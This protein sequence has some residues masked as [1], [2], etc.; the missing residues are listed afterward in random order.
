[1]KNNAVIQNKDVAEKVYEVKPGDVISLENY[2]LDNLTF[3]SAG[4]HLVIKAQGKGDVTLLNFDLAANEGE[5]VVFELPDGTRVNAKDFVQLLNVPVNDIEPAAGPQSGT[6]STV[7]ED[8][9]F[10]EP[11]IISD[12]YSADNPISLV[13]D[14]IPF[15]NS[16]FR[17]DDETLEEDGVITNAN[18]PPAPNTSPD[19]VNDS[20]NVDED[21]ALNLT[22]AQ[23]LANDTDI[24]GDALSV[25]SVDSTTT[26]GGTVS[27]NPT[28]GAIVYTPA[29]NY[30]GADSFTYTISDGNGGVDTAT[31]NINVSPIN[32]A[33]DAVNDSFNVDEDNALN[34]TV[35]QLLANDTDIDGDAL[36]VTSVDSTTTNGGTVSYNPTTGAIVYTPAANYNGADSFTYTISDGN[37]GVDT[38]TVN[39][40]VNPINDAPDAVND[41]D[42]AEYILLGTKT[43]SGTMADWGTKLADGRVSFNEN[44]IQGIIEGINKNGSSGE[45]RYS[46]GNSGGGKNDFGIGVKSGGSDEIDLGESII[47]NFDT[48]LTSAKIGLDSLYSHFT[49]GARQDARAS[50]KA[51]KDGLLVASGEVFNDGSNSDGD[52]KRETNVFEIQQPFDKLEFETV[53]PTSNSNSNFVIRYIEATTAGEYVTDEDVSLNL[54]AAQ[55]LAND[56]DPDGDALS[57]TSVDSTTTNGGAV[58]YNPATGAIVYTPAANYNGADSFSYTISDGNGGV[59]SATV[60]LYVAPV[61]DAPVAQ[62]N[63]FSGQEDTAL[64]FTLAQLLANDSDVDGDSLSLSSFTASTALGGTLTYNASSQTFTYNPAQDVNGRDSMTYTITDGK[65]GYSTATIFIDLADTPD[66]TEAPKLSFTGKC[67][68]FGPDVVDVVKDVKLTDVDSQN[69]MSAQVTISQNHK[70]GDVIELTGLNIQNGQIDGTNIQ[71]SYNGH[72]GVLN[73]TGVDSLAHYKSALAALQFDANGTEGTRELSVTVTDESG[74]ASNVATLVANVTNDVQDGTSGADTL[75]GTDTNDYIQGHAGDDI[76]NAQNGN[77]SLHGGDG[78]DT[79]T[80]GLGNDAV[81]GDDG[82]DTLHGDDPTQAAQGG[83]DCLHGGAGQDVL[84]GYG[85]HDFLEGGEGRDILY[86]GAGNDRLVDYGKNSTILHTYNLVFVVDIS[87]SMTAR[88]NN[89]S[90]ETRFDLV[91]QAIQSILADFQTDG[92]QVNLSLVSFNTGAQS[93]EFS[94]NDYNALTTA[95]SGM[96][97]Y[98]G[99]NFVAPLNEAKGLFD[100]DISIAP[101]GDTHHNV[102]YFFSDGQPSYYGRV[103]NLSYDWGQY[104]NDNDIESHAL[105]VGVAPYRHL[106]PIDNTN[107]VEQYNQGDDLDANPQKEMSGG[108]VMYGDAGDDYIDGGLGMDK[109]YGGA[110]NDTLVFD[111]EDSVIDGGTGFDTLKITDQTA[112]V[113]FGHFGINGI[114]AVDMANQAQ[115]S[116]QLNA[117]DV[118]GNT[119]SGQLVISGDTGD[120]VHADEY[121]VRGNDQTI[122]GVKYAQYT[123]SGSNSASI[124]VEVGLELN[125]TVVNEQ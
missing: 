25:T 121:T 110:D 32:D 28:T 82:D 115:T 65:G 63:V 33:P 107:G 86:G 69:L 117:S 47:V 16:F 122:D 106:E 71:V 125:G 14:P 85:G 67:Y 57:V 103:D 124:L 26:N 48:V 19:A 51:Y 60:Y 27:Y 29:A 76:I 44:G 41:G 77:D 8:G 66:L 53:S 54:T 45:V 15:N 79:L 6:Q 98:G 2:S 56:S 78:N 102:M 12:T 109:L 35:A 5:P 93:T 101:S 55:L 70:L 42:N 22:A 40:N 97:I 46:I 88:D 49:P 120:I 104:V 18:Q 21:N 36:S 123:T 30:N 3:A 38:A 81:F 50:W 61:N 95:L 20:F 68:A 116:L 58:S 72:T 37:G 96:N 113:D 112:V 13:I 80:A 9:G 74:A 84:Y 119:D 11:R 105:A 91:Q 43:F 62:D 17:V 92:Y 94:V 7:E 59:D 64:N 89:T 1:M 90:G 24:D 39:I 118:L 114:D 23:L 4:T 100:N 34:L 108:D 73:L 99:T 83:D 75:V 31:V 111:S 87:G 52:G 10:E